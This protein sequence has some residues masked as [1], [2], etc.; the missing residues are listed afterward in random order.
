MISPLKTSHKKKEGRKNPQQEKLE[1]NNTHKEKC[2]N[3]ITLKK[4]PRLPLNAQV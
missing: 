2:P 3:E 1:K 4:N